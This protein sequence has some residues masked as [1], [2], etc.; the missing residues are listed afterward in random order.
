MRP[1]RTPYPYYFGA[2]LHARSLFGHVLDAGR[3]RLVG[4]RPT[5]EPSRCGQVFPVACGRGVACREAEV[6]SHSREPHGSRF[7]CQVGGP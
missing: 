5:K 4:R 2:D 3:K 1:Y 7:L 6:G